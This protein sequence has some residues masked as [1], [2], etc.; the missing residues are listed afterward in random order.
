MWRAIL[1]LLIHDW[2]KLSQ[3]HWSWRHYYLRINCQYLIEWWLNL[4]LL[5]RHAIF[6]YLQL[7]IWFIKS[8]HHELHILEQLKYFLKLCWFIV[9]ESLNVPPLKLQRWQYRAD[10]MQ[11]SIQVLMPIY[12]AIRLLNLRWNWSE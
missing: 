1:C 7:Q 9:Y 4:F 6:W 11:W 5:P 10:I 3:L 2:H 8:I 12:S